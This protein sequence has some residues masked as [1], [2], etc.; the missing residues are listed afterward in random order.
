MRIL[1]KYCT[2]SA[3]CDSEEKRRESIVAALSDC[4]A[5]LTMK[6]GYQVQKRLLKRGIMSV[7]YCYTIESGLFY[8]VEQLELKAAAV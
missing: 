5:V 8:T 6:I 7:E 1:E 4:D 2:G 3:N